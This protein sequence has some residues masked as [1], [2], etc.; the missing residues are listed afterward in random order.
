MKEGNYFKRLDS[1]GKL[2]S[3]AVIKTATKI[4]DGSH[5]LLPKEFIG[6]KVIIFYKDLKKLNLILDKTMA[7]IIEEMKNEDRK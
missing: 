3:F 5:I 7:R 6:K 2:E 1:K 4:G